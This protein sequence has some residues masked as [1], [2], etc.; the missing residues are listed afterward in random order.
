MLLLYWCQY[1]S[2]CKSLLV[3]YSGKWPSILVLSVITLNSLRNLVCL[4]SRRR[5]R[6]VVSPMQSL[7]QQVTGASVL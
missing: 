2:L 3:E 6:V 4:H 5:F 1:R 7:K